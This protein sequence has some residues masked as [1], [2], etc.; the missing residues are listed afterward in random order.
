MVVVLTVAVAAAAVATA[1][2]VLAPATTDVVA[3]QNVDA[4]ETVMDCTTA[5]LVH[6]MNCK[7]NNIMVEVR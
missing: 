4:A 7:T 3:V 1:A 2:V 5:A 6:K